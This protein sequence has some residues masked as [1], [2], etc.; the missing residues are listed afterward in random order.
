MSIK[1]VS[2]VW[3]KPQTQQI[4]KMLRDAGVNVEKIE[5]GYQAYAGEHLIFK[6]MVGT[7]GYLVRYAEKLFVPENPVPPLKSKIKRAKTA[8]P[9]H[10]EKTTM[11]RYRVSESKDGKK[12][13]IL[14]DFYSRL[15]AN[16]YAKAVAQLHANY[17]VKI[18][19]L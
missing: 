18:D 10:R 3:N 11:L 16:N 19:Q 12:W 5:N 7:R 4:I 9:V 13:I 15:V 6:A 8:K 1:M 2:K 17:Y 14:A